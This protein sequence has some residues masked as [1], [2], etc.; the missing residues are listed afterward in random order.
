MIADQIV[1]VVFPNM[2]TTQGPNS[3]VL[4]TGEGPRDFFWSEI[5][6]QSDFLGSMKDAGIFLGCE[7][8]TKGFY[9]VY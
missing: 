5:L 2:L 8:K 3:H 9:W 7:K 6:A 4:M 1:I